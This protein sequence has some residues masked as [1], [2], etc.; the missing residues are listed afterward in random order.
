MRILSLAGSATPPFPAAPRRPAGLALSSLAFCG[1]I[2]DAAKSGDLE[3]VKA[4]LKDKRGLV[5][6]KD[7]GGGGNYTFSAFS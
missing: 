1:E 5:F 3:K 7:N 4:L 2:H 6:S